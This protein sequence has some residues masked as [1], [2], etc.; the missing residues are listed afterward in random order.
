[1]KTR[2]RAWSNA[3]TL[4]ISAALGV[5]MIA[6][7]GG[8]GSSGPA[9]STTAAAART[10]AMSAPALV[11]AAQAAL[12]AGGSVHI[13]WKVDAG[14]QTEDYSVDAT[15]TG[16]RQVITLDVTQHVTILL[17]DG[18]DYVQ[19]NLT[20]MERFFGVPAG[21]AEQF[22]GQ[23]IAI[24]PTQKI[25]DTSYAS[26]TAGITLQS[27]AAT[28]F[29]PFGGNPARI[30]PTTIAGLPVAGV[31]VA[32]PASSGVPASARQ[33]LY[34][35]DDAARRPVLV[36]VLGDGRDT[37]RTSFSKWHE[38]LTLTAPA[39]PVSALLVTPVSSTT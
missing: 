35:S 22:Q 29:L 8:S 5:G 13:D 32:M 16:G 20:A 19:A 11:R 6:G 24:R 12:R 34:V 18:V 38:K 36:E 2:G 1:M 4:G 28:D 31:Q 39:D 15:A 26:V 17:I 30:K 3:I 10:A 21:P 23:W 25:G 37:Y 27:I 33:V 7:C 14:G 9:A